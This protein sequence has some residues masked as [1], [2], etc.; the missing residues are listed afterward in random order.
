MW[1]SENPTE[2]DPTK[3]NLLVG[4]TQSISDFRFTAQPMH[5]GIHIPLVGVRMH[6]QLQTER[7]PV[8]RI[9]PLKLHVLVHFKHIF[10]TL[11]TSNRGVRKPL[12]WIGPNFTVCSLPSFSRVASQFLTLVRPTPPYG[13]GWSFCRVT[14]NQSHTN[15][16][17]CQDIK[18][19]SY[20]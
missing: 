4:P 5:K 14:Y 18:Q 8:F 7:G 3:A 13:A 2:H 19:L 16:H 6:F 17:Q 15:R 10:Y 12:L 11:S 9:F 1:K 20:C